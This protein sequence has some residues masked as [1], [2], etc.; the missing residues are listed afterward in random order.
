MQC[1]FLLLCTTNVN[2]HCQF[3]SGLLA[4]KSS[5]NTYCTVMETRSM[6][7]KLAQLRQ[8]SAN[9][10]I[11]LCLQPQQVM[12]VDCGITAAS[13]SLRRCISRPDQAVHARCDV[14]LCKKA[15]VMPNGFQSATIMVMI[16]APAVCNASFA[17]SMSKWRLYDASGLAL[18]CLFAG[19]LLDQPLCS[20]ISSKAELR[21]LQRVSI[22]SF[23]QCCAWVQSNY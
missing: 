4:N 9:V 20:M 16:T 8:C 11:T 23:K 5:N 13:S 21:R 14:H 17:L 12:V 6:T 2:T 18:L 1:S 15:T 19:F 7:E 10:S 3:V 22:C